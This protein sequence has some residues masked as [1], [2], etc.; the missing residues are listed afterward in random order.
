MHKASQ[1]YKRRG[2]IQIV[3]ELGLIYAIIVYDVS[4]ER[5]AKVNRYLKRYLLWIQNFVF[6]G[7]LR[8]STLDRLITGL[9]EI[10]DPED[11]VLIYKLKTDKYVERIKLGKMDQDIHNVI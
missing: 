3:Q 1:G 8:E 10:I 7:E 5:V 9:S 4:V 6:E 2:E 11:R